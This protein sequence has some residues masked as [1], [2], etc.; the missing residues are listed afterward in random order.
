MKQEIEK[1]IAKEIRPILAAHGG[2][3]ELV[4]V[5][6]EETIKIRLTGACSTCPGQQHTVQQLLEEKIKESY[7]QI[8]CVSLQSNVN[9]EL[10]NQA[11]EIIRKKR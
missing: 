8:K 2:G 10:I 4:E 5:A 1:I 3:I 9:E 7:P 11:L 6:N